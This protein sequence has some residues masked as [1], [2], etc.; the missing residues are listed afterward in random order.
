MR[1]LL[2]NII[3]TFFPAHCLLCN[4]PCTN[5]HGFCNPCFGVLPHNHARCKRCGLSL[6]FSDEQI[7]CGECIAN[8]P[9]FDRA[10]ALFDYEQPISSLIWRLKFSGH[11]SVARIFSACWINYLTEYQQENTLPE[12]IIPVPLYHSRLKHRGFNQALEIAKPIGKHFHIPIDTRTCIRIKN[13]QAQS[14]LP[15]NKRKNNVNNAFGLSYPLTAKH[16]AIIDDVMTT[17]N[18][19]SE[20]SYLLKKSGVLKI[21]VWCCARAS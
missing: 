1:P 3:Q 19:V 10:I 5:S 14:S 17:G 4:A 6:P 16:V 18:T 15:A 8:P 7:N 21:D 12:L 2:K 13:T 20:I 11:L 9:P